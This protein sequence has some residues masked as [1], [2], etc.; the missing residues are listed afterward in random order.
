VDDLF[1]TPNGDPSDD[2]FTADNEEHLFYA[3]VLSEHNE[4]TDDAVA[5]QA[6]LSTIIDTRLSRAIPQQD[7]AAGKPPTLAFT[8][9]PC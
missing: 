8:L 4:L 1:A 7:L 2:T 3:K 5:P 9:L 6:L